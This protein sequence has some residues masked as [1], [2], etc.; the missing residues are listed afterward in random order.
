MKDTLQR[1]ARSLIG[2]RYAVYHRVPFKNRRD[3]PIPCSGVAFYRS[4][5]GPIP[6]ADI[7]ERCLTCG[8]QIRSH[9]LG[10]HEVTDPSVIH[11]PRENLLANPFDVLRHPPR[12]PRR[13]PRHV[14]Q[15]VVE[16]E[17]GRP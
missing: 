7:P 9:Q 14:G 5:K 12:M 10:L 11:I 3:A 4:V 2:Q 17:D 16:R 13:R 15:I 6:A 8:Q 1:W